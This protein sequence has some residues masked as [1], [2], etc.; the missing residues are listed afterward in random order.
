MF[1]SLSICLSQR[2]LKTIE[3]LRDKKISSIYKNLSF[4]AITVVNKPKLHIEHERT[5][6]VVGKIRKKTNNATKSNK[7]K[8]ILELFRLVHIAIVL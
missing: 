8:N 1:V 4:V 5:I 6:G 3:K 7:S 2:H